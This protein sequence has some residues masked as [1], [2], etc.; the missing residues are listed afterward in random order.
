MYS[1]SVQACPSESS[2]SSARFRSLGLISTVTIEGE[3]NFE[4]HSPTVPDLFWEQ[5][6]RLS[7]RP[8]V[9]S[10]SRHHWRPLTWG[11]MRRRAEQTAQGLLAMGVT[12]GERLAIMAESC[13]EWVIVDL[14]CAAIGVTTIAISPQYPIDEV[15]HILVDSDAVAFVVDRTYELT[16][17]HIAFLVRSG[18]SLIVALQGSIPDVSERSL[19][20]CGPWRHRDPRSHTRG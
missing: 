4:H 7:T 20:G 11:Q 15:H 5:S 6:Q 17:G 16:D 8:M 12:P 14:A 2:F 10:R 1:Q 13:I 9:F 18:I 19:G 3:L